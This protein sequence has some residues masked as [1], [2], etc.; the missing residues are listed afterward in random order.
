MAVF[1]EGH[2]PTDP[3]TFSEAVMGRI[4]EALAFEQGNHRIGL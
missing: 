1:S 4:C 2:A 3:F